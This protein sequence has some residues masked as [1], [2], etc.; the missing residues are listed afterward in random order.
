MSLKNE[1]RSSTLPTEIQEL[2]LRVVR[3]TKLRPKEKADVARELITHFED[4]IEQGGTPTEAIAAYGDEKTAALLLRK[5]CK[6]KRWWVEVLFVR[7]TKY[8]AC[9]FGCVVLIYLV[10]VFFALQREP[11]IAVDYVA[12]LNETAAAVPENERA[13][14]MYRKAILAINKTPQ[15]EVEIDGRPVTPTW[16]DGAGWDV[17]EEWILSHRE[18]SNFIREGAMKSGMGF[19]TSNQIAEEDKELWPEQYEQNQ[20]QSQHPILTI[21]FPQLG[22]LRSMARLLQFDAF[23]AASK[24]ESKR[25]FEDIQA[26][27]RLGRH[28]QEHSTLINDLVAMAIYN[29]AFQTTGKILEKEPKVLLPELNALKQ[30]LLSLDTELEV[31]FDG[32]RMFILDL[33]QRTY[34]DDGNGDGKLVPRNMVEM[35]SLLYEPSIASDPTVFLAPF[36]DLLIASRKEML[37]HYDSYIALVEKYRSVPL[38]EWDDAVLECNRQLESRVGNSFLNKY[39]FLDLLMPVLDRALLAGKYTKASRD[40]LIATMYAV[41]AKQ[42]TGSWPTDLT[43]A[44]VVDPWSGEPWS[45]TTID[46][47]PK[48]YSIGIDKDDDNGTYHDKAK[49][50][51]PDFADIPDGDWVVWPIPE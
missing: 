1:V 2:I 10:M 14:P 26:M 16:V 43:L 36:G 21:L 51:Q 11:T 23:D 39:Y 3:R 40:G 47:A 6:R 27:I 34:T 28:T 38:N 15:P 4:A 45:I 42:G 31:R 7:A 46:S 35:M 49:E 41:E 18:T 29:T 24:G 44:G 12:K 48:I 8:A 32:E 50:W 20:E 22:G 17:Y 37:D 33:L 25:C 13:W 9:G 19:I 30:L 5:A